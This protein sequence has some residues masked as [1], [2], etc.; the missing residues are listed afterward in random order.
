MM[1]TKVD[2]FT[3]SSVEEALL[4]LRDNSQGTR[5]IAGGT[6]MIIQLKDRLVMADRLMN[7]EGLNE[8]R[9][10]RV[11]SDLIRIGATTTYTDIL[12]SN[13]TKRYMPILVQA[14]STVGGVQMQNKGTIGGNLGNASPAA[15]SIPPLYALDA[16]VV[17]Q[18]L[19]SEREL[20]IEE[21]F[22][23]P[24]R[25]DL[26]AGE[27]IAEVN[28]KPMNSDEDGVF[29][30]LGLRESNAISVVSLA[31]WVR[32]GKPRFFNDVRMAL[33]A[34]AP[35]V[36]RA[37]K[38]EELSKSILM[39]GE[40]IWRVAEL[41]QESAKPISDIRGSAD[42]RQSMVKSLTYQALAQLSGAA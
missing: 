7:I 34:V 39:T 23:G 17:L 4:F 42:Y 11:D 22:L 15:D 31:M 38:A 16:K 18:S 37:R 13:I 32:R 20:P 24:R 2:V 28:L 5:V 1:L 3:P 10:I 14:A 36:V 12:R 40:N 19:R 6:D 21:F 30:K 41:A 9:Y 26:R 8:L 33:G 25:V 29:L 27:L 35:T